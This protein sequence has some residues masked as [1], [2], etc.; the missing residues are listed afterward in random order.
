MTKQVICYI[1]NHI[2]HFWIPDW[3]FGQAQS[4]KLIIFVFKI[5]D[6]NVYFSRT[7]WKKIVI[8]RLLDSSMFFQVQYKF[9]TAAH[10]IPWKCFVHQLN[11]DVVLSF[12]WGRKE[13]PT[14]NW[15]SILENSLHFHYFVF[16]KINNPNSLAPYISFFSTFKKKSNPITWPKKHDP[17]KWPNK[18]WLV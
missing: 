10:L 9:F 11:W 7:F 2:L 13:K 17:V 1:S 16:N 12:W 6:R 8:L 15:K 4:S 3:Y 18:T 5:S 14:K